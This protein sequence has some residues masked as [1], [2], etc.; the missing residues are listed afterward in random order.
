MEAYLHFLEQK[1]EWVFSKIEPTHFRNC[2]KCLVDE[3]RRKGK[4][5]S[6]QLSA[7]P[8]PHSADFAY[9]RLH[10]IL[11]SPTSITSKCCQWAGLSTDLLWAS[12]QF[13]CDMLSVFVHFL[14]GKI[15]SSF[16]Q[17]IQIY[18]IF[19]SNSFSDAAKADKGT[20]GSLLQFPLSTY[21]IF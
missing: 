21:Y 9:C 16:W 1:G 11:A 5:F 20:E 6:K 4:S 3:R 7:P 2:L 18:R 19:T 17:M 10:R 8:C 15:T 13:A 14:C 12:W